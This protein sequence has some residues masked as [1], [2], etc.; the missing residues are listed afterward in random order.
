MENGDIN[1]AEWANIPN[2]NTLDDVV[3]LLI[4]LQLFFD[5]LIGMIFGYI[6]FYGNRE[7]PGISF[8]ITNER[9]RLFSRMLLLTGCHTL[10]DQPSS[11]WQ[12][13]T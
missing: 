5:I 13:T 3:T 2:F 12:R 4:L 7:K 11:L 6:N 9:P 1:V 10:P 8:E